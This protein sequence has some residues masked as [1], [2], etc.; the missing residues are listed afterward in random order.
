MLRNRIVLFFSFLSIVVVM[1]VGCGHDPISPGDNVSPGVSLEV[2]LP[3]LDSGYIDAPDPPNFASFE[4]RVNVRDTVTLRRLHY[5]PIETRGRIHVGEANEGNA[6]IIPPRTTT[7]TTMPSGTSQTIVIRLTAADTGLAQVTVDA[8]TS[9]NALMRS[10]TQSFT[11][12]YR[13]AGGN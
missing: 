13:P 2:I 8:F 3:S 1:I 10:V 4:V 12:R 7:D 5:I 9:E 11:V 6:I